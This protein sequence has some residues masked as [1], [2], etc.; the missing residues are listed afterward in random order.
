[1]L[2]LEFAEDEEGGFSKAQ[3]QNWI[4]FP[5]VGLRCFLRLFYRKELAIANLA[6]MPGV[7]R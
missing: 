4:Y 3:E 2:A 6:Y 1:V 7:E 5:P